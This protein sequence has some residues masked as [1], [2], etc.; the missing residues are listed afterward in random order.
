MRAEPCL[1]QLADALLSGLPRLSGP[2]S[3][4]LLR[5]RLACFLPGWREGADWRRQPVRLKRPWS[6]IFPVRVRTV[7]FLVAGR[8]VPRVYID[9]K[10]VHREPA[11]AQPSTKEQ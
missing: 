2:F 7:V 1:G 3:P 10:L 5:A 8:A 4:A 6:P 11:A 9:G